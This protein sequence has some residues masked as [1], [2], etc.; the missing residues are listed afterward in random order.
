MLKMILNNSIFPTSIPPPSPSPSLSCSCRSIDQEPWVDFAHHFLGRA[1]YW[2]ED[3]F[4]TADFAECE[5][6]L[7]VAID[8][9]MVMVMMV[10]KGSR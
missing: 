7:R 9:V 3:D 2:A 4:L 1:L 6:S 8:Q 10:T 5:V